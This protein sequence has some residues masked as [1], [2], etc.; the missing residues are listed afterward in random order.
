M[1]IELGRVCR[2]QH[3]MRQDGRSPPVLLPARSAGTSASTSAML[4]VQNRTKKDGGLEE[5][6]V[7]IGMCFR[8]MRPQKPY[9]VEFISRLGGAAGQG[10]IYAG[11]YNRNVYAGG[12]RKTLLPLV[13]GPP[14]RRIDDGTGSGMLAGRWYMME[15]ASF[16]LVSSTQMVVSY[17]D[18]T[19]LARFTYSAHSPNGLGCG[20]HTEVRTPQ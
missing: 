18:H 10:C 14:N 2:V 12:V 19:A 13:Y 7:N 16:Q 6:I 20:T 9:S 1:I 5:R 11:V 8:L 3:G 4:P 17:T 15:T